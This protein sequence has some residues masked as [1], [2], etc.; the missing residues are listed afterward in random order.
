MNILEFVSKFPDEQSCRLDFK[1]KR[2]DQG[3]FC[4]KCSSE[5]HY[6]L[7]NKWQWQCKNS[8]FRTTLR[9]GTIM[10]N[11]NM[12]VRSWYLCMAQIKKIIQSMSE[13]VSFLQV[14]VKLEQIV[15]SL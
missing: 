4:K 5:V 6:W 13:L 2:E 1:N 11:S 8:N 7:K 9:S 14:L 10:E 12:P 3:V 15:K